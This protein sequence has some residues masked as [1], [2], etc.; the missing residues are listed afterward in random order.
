MLPSLP[1]ALSRVEITRRVDERDAETL[2]SARGDDLERLLAV[3]SAVRDE[4]LD[5]S[6]RTGVITYSKKVFIPITF[7]CQDRCH[8]CTFV[9]TPGGLLAMGKPSYMSP[10]EILEVA[11]AGAALGCKEALFTLGDRP[12]NRW[13]S[14]RA[15]LAEHGYASTI[16]YIRAMA[17]LVLEETG[18][19]P[20]LNPGVMSFSEL[21]ALRPV[22]P[23]MGMM[24]ETTATRL[25][26]EKGGVH[27]GSP[28][29][30]PALR[31]RVLDDAGRSRV[32]FTTGVLLGI[33]EDDAERVE[34]L[35]AIR[36]SHERH[37][38]I[39][40]TIVQ[41]FRAK[42]KTAMQNERDLAVEEYAA[43]VAVARLVMGPDATI[44]APPN[45]TDA[46]ELGLL[47]RAGIDDWGGV[48]PL[49]AD[50][51]NPERPWPEL[52]EL[53]RLTAAAGFELRERLTAHP[54]FVT[55]SGGDDWLDARL[56]AHVDAL[57]LP[58]GLADEAAPVVGRPWAAPPVARR[59][60]APLARA[61]VDPAGLS[62]EDYVA[63]LAS[64]GAEL[65][66]LA[67]LAHDVR[68]QTVGP[69]VSFVI[70]RN[71]DSSLLGSVLD[72]SLVG[73]LADEAASLG[74][75]EICV[76]GAVPAHL[77]GGAYLDIVH[78]LHERQP[79]IHLHAFR[80]TEVADG[81]ARLGIPVRAF[82]ERLRD[83]GVGTVPGTGARILDDRIRALLSA[84]TDPPARSWIDTVESAHSAGLRSTATMV[85]GHVESPADQVAHLRALAGIH[86]RTGGF[87]EFIAMPFVPLDS[88]PVAGARPGPTVRESRAVH[89]VARLMLHGRIDHVQ[90]AWTKL[91]LSTTQAVLR[92]GA[93]D[94]GG[95]LLD[96]TIAPEAGAEAHRSLAIADVERLAAE[97]G[98]VARQRTTDY[99]TPTPQQLAHARR[100]EAPAATRLHLTLAR[101]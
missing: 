88:P 84:D 46:T 79:G 62:D 25:W 59:G 15:W 42:P 32:P 20:H 93:D 58:S 51:V 85:Y 95:L 38:H 41:N 2:L 67:A 69:D 57:A 11:R 97:I 83:A 26:S 24:L 91:G 43:A 6:D 13:P 39:Q 96:G 100:P 22:A 47:I 30:D 5:R 66:A 71:L 12:E 19:L 65:E 90:A 89:A 31:L 60:S 1:D 73:D 8:Y 82:Y 99:G 64:D 3:A 37:G 16:D 27:Y 21:Q 53:A 48:S 56:R 23:S 75:T 45:L 10:E 36:A 35:F 54:P 9:E 78:A 7:L 74:A 70:N 80:P 33:G 17:R 98:A 86:D 68:V 55:S 63:L 77:P 52:D 44:Q 34:S 61:A 81:A 87:T 29:K 101:A 14:A 28:D 40:E 18:L 4:G 50:H 94:A 49:T 92:G 72:L 76:Q